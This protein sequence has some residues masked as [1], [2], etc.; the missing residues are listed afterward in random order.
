MAQQQQLRAYLTALSH[1][2][3]KLDRDHFTLVD[4]IVSMPWTTMEVSFVKSYISF[5][6]MLV[7]AR[8][9]YLALVLERA[10]ESLTYRKY[11]IIS[12]LWVHSCS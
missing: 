11:T 3:S 7:S 10:A 4:A 2:V 9:E 8:P 12:V 5:V 1:V 6:A